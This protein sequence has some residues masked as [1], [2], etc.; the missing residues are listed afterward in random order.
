MEPPQPGAKRRRTE[1]SAAAARPA[2]APRSAAA[3][4]AGGADA[5]CVVGPNVQLA[6]RLRTT[7]EP[8]SELQIQDVERCALAALG[9]LDPLLRHIVTVKLVRNERRNFVNIRIRKPYVPLVHAQTLGSGTRYFFFLSVHLEPFV[10]VV[11]IHPERGPRGTW[12]A[13]DAAELRQA[14]DSFKA[15]HG[16]HRE[17]YRYDDA[18]PQADELGAVLQTMARRPAAPFTL[19]IRIATQM[20]TALAPTLRLLLKPGPLRE[21]I[22]AVETL[23]SSDVYDALTGIEP[24]LAHFVQR[25]RRGD[26][27]ELALYYLATIYTAEHH[28]VIYDVHLSDKFEPFAVVS[29]THRR[30]GKLLRLSLQQLADLE[31]TLKG[32]RRKYSVRKTPLFAPF[33]SK[34]EHFTKTGSGQT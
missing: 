10:N 16:V 2:W 13:I 30:H 15:R 26:Y 21:V 33:I 6:E 8:L 18:K 9:E 23:P 7:P 14:I 3:A 24:A 25:G 1:G 27:P 20:F 29:A 22:H 4:A 34:N 17:S 31:E 19:A 11:A 12:G 28:D 32:F 5:A